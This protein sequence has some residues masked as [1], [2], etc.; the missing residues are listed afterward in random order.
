M[1]AQLRERVPGMKPNISTKKAEAFP[2]VKTTGGKVL[3]LGGW[4]GHEQMGSRE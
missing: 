2:A 3:R 1:A 4:R